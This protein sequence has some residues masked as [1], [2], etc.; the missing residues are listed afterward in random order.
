MQ[1]KDLSR[2]DKIK[3]FESWI[4]GDLIQYKLGGLWEDAAQPYFGAHTD[5]RAVNASN[6][7]SLLNRIV[8]YHNN[9]NKARLESAI[10]KAEIVIKHHKAKR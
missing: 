1:F 9:G 7:L 6:L 3:L 2:E 5:Y 10:N 4:D 8:N